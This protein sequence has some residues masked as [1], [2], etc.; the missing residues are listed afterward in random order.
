MHPERILGRVV[1]LEVVGELDL[2][3]SRWCRRTA[4][5]HRAGGGPRRR[6][7]PFAQV[8]ERVEQE[9]HRP[10]AAVGVDLGEPVD[11]DLR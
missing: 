6:R 5:R 3:R 8:V 4:R 2:D 7:R 9:V 10:V 1:V 11:V